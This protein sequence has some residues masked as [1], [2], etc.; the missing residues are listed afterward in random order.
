MTRELTPIGDPDSLEVELARSILPMA[1]SNVFGLIAIAPVIVLIGGDRLDPTLT[2]FWALAMW[3][4][5]LGQ[6]FVL[7]AN[8]LMTER[9]HVWTRLYCVLEILIGAVCGTVPLLAAGP[10]YHF[11]VDLVALTF[12]VVVTAA[13]AISFVGSA[14]I[15]RA[16]IIS[17]W[18]TAVTAWTARAEWGLAGIGLIAM[19]AATSYNR[20]MARFL[21]GWL[22]AR[23][24]ADGLAD[25]LRHRAT[26]DELT[27]C[28]DRR[29]LQEA[30]GGQPPPPE[31]TA[32]LFLD[33]DDFKEVN[34]VYGHAFG[35][36]VLRAAAERITGLMPSGTLIGRFGED[37]FVVVVPGLD[38][39]AI[40]GLG[41]DVI[42]AL[43]DP[44]S[45]DP[46]VTVAASIGYSRWRPEQSVDDVLGEADL[47]MYQAKNEGGGA[48]AVFDAAAG[49]ARRNRLVLARE[50]R[51]AVAERRLAVAAQPIVA[52]G[53]DGSANRVLACELLARWD[54]DGRPIGPG[55]FIPL[56][57]HLELD[58]DIGRFMLDSAADAASRLPG[59]S[60]TVNISARHLLSGTLACD[61]EQS[62]RSFGV[63]PRMLAVELTESQ[64]LS[65]T[66][67]ARVQLGHLRDL[68]VQVWVDDFGTG[69]SSLALL[70]TVPVTG[71]KLGP[72][73]G[74]R[75]AASARQ[76]TVV[77]KTAE[78]ADELGVGVLVEGVEDAVTA[79]LVRS[80]GIATA[81]GYHFGRPAPLESLLAQAIPS[82]TGPRPADSATAPP[83]GAT[84]P[85]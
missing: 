45:T 7:R 54:W 17:L 5:A 63:S 55:V 41:D 43:R 26:H 64:V 76:R 6:A 79:A 15:F 18:L 40:R 50:L 74:L 10:A 82:Q 21:R 48:I 27:G 44:V 11:T 30:M 75:L 33:L 31:G 20:S 56:A 14:P 77:T 28:L 69:F 49:Q 3:A 16:F 65:D 19:I 32:V 1:R 62:C 60:F 9:V 78:L 24:E 47:A 59:M 12:G 22:Q 29:G 83:A 53:P 2:L 34:D 51:T 36:E 58:A 39:V 25:Q 13:A 66:L 52:L 38:D 71:L 80:S 73:F 37:E 84:Q 85:S 61:I 57:E 23:H 70:D 68:G 8:R 42:A 81:Q 46:V 4:G 67:S 72:E 35:D